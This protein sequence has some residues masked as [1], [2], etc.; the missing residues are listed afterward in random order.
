MRIVFDARCFFEIKTG[1]GYYAYNLIKHLLDTNGDNHYTL[2]YGV[3]LRPSKEPLPDFSKKGV[4]T[5]LIKYPGRI[6]D[7]VVDRFPSF[8]VDFLIGQYDVF[9]SPSFLPPPLRG[10]TVITVHDLAYHLYPRFF[11]PSMIR[12]L[13]RHLSRAAE[14]AK[15][16]IAD[17]RNTKND[18]VEILG[19]NPE[20]IV[21]IY[22]AASDI[23]RPIDDKEKVARV[24]GRYGIDA[25]YIGFFGTIEPRKNVATLIRAYGDLKRKN[26]DLP[27]KL[28]LAGQKGWKYEDVFDVISSLGLEEGVVFTEYVAEEDLPLLM[29]GADVVVYPSLYEGFGLPPLEAMACGR[30][31]ITSNT[32]SLLEIVGD[33]AIMVDP[34][35]VEEL[36]AAM[37]KVL[38]DTALKKEMIRKGLER[39]KMFSWDKTAKETIK[40]YEDVCRCG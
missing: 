13:Q 31:V 16:I 34:Q 10:K 15:R 9:H 26:P 22:P 27:Q 29:N 18:L 23:Y 14:E 28:V 11:P 2:F 32:S 25:D 3:A 39:A 19:V 21:V 37:E 40:V 4:D 12:P 38:S 30:P 17:S 5:I 35:S 6:F 36:S 24:K 1:V 20:K 8:R 7:F 33:A